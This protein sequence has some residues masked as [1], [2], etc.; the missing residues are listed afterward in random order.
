MLVTAIS[1]NVLT[2]TRGVE[3]STAVAHGVGEIAF[4]ALTAGSLARLCRQSLNG[5]NVSARREIN[6]TGT[7][8]TLTDDPTNDKVDIAVAGGSAA[9]PVT[10]TAPPTTGWTAINMTGNAVYTLAANYATTWN[11]SGPGSAGEM[12]SALVRSAPA[13][14][15]SITVR[16]IPT[17]PQN[18]S[19]SISGLFAGLCVRD[20]GTGAMVALCLTEAGFADAFKLNGQS[21]TSLTARTGGSISSVYCPANQAAYLKVRDD[22]TNIA[23]SCSSDG[24]NFIQQF[25]SSRT[26][27]MTNPTTVGFFIDS[28]SGASTNPVGATLMSWAVG[29]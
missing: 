8:V 24:I 19:G 10:D 29:S 25:S 9:Y 21:W 3:G 11:P 13:T 2:V 14:P 23:F 7:T 1:G 22:G 5:T 16:L 15:Y 18:V 4:L 12:V 27:Y 17:L 28:A 20:P 26:L 6:F